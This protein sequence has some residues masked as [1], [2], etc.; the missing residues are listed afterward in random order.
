MKLFPLAIIVGL[1][2][3][4]VWLCAAVVR[5][6][7]YRHANFVGMCTKY[8]IA[9]PIQRIQREECLEKTPTRTQWYLHLLNGLKVL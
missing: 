1:V 4:I 6:E 3:V 2:V 5:L 8:N 7:N 9:D